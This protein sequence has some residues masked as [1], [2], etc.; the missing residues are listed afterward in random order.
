MS[1]YSWNTSKKN[2]YIILD[3]EYIVRS[4]QTSASGGVLCFLCHVPVYLTSLAMKS[5]PTDLSLEG[6]LLGMLEPT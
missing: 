4:L 1:G 6:P 3:L 2:N 5:L